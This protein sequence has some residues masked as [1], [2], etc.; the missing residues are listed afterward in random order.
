MKPKP[1]HSALVLVVF[2]FAM[3]G[4]AALVEAKNKR[5]AESTPFSICPLCEQEV[6]P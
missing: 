4:I 5:Q 6:R 1:E 3:A 2:V